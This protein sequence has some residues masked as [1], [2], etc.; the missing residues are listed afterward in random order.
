MQHESRQAEVLL[1]SLLASCA[2]VSR[3]RRQMQ[4]CFYAG[5]LSASPRP[6]RK[7]IANH[8]GGEFPRIATIFRSQR[9]VWKRSPGQSGRQIKGTST[10]DKRTAA[11]FISTTR[12]HVVRLSKG[13]PI[14]L[15]ALEYSLRHWT[16]RK[17]NS[18]P[19]VGDPRQ[20]FIVQVIIAGR[21]TAFL[22]AAA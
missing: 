5:L 11:S 21:P 16:S 1:L 2:N 7:D 17:S 18:R 9:G 3:V 4:R 22:F 8:S 14:N 10:P 15:L 19:V 20:G 13:P 6:P 12:C